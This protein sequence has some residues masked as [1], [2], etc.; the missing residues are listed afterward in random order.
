L[1]NTYTTDKTA[2]N[3][4]MGDNILNNDTETREFRM[5]V[6]AKD[7]TGDSNKLRLVGIACVKNC[8]PTV[9]VIPIS[10]T[11]KYWSNITSWPLGKLPVEGDE[12]EI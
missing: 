9:V 4:T 1:N 2:G 11:V 5:A 6:N 7:I 12:V 8:V 3:L 10:D